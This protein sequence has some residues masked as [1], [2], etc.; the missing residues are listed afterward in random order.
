MKLN[1]RRLLL[2]L[3]ERGYELSEIE[4]QRV[5]S[6]S[7][8][9]LRT[10]QWQIL[11]VGQYGRQGDHQLYLGDAV[12]QIQKLEE[13]D[14]EDAEVKTTD[15]PVLRPREREDAALLFPE[16]APMPSGKRT[17]RAVRSDGLVSW[18]TGGPVHA[19]VAHTGRAY[20]RAALSQS[21]SRIEDGLLNHFRERLG[22]QYPKALDHP[23]GQLFLRTGVPVVGLL[24]A[25]MRPES[26]F[27]RIV[28]EAAQIMLDGAA[29]RSVEWAEPVLD[30]ALQ[31]FAETVE[32][33]GLLPSKNSPR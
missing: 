30:Q 12:P 20:G 26:K 32:H 1:G 2:E 3:A 23:L 18:V 11:S 33:A 10:S 14:V 25:E 24:L 19:V 5:S 7:N 31:L 22:D 6:A 15:Y 17:G 27:A 8:F 21:A 16:E 13:F 4:A 9:F 28:G 29:Q